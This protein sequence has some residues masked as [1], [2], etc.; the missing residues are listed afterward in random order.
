MT[1][2][3]PTL[4]A[5]QLKVAVDELKARRGAPPWNERIVANDR[6]VVTVICQPPGHLNDWHYHIVEECWHVHEGTISWT[7]EGEPEPVIVSAGEWILAPA[8][9]FHFIEVLGDRPAIRIAVSV[10]GEPH[11]HTR[12]D[13]PLIYHLTPA[14]EW[15][16]ARAAGA[17]RVSTLGTTLDEVGFIHCSRAGQVAGVANRFYREQTDLVL[18]TI[19]EQRVRPEIRYEAAP[20]SAEP[21][22]HIHGPLNLDAVVE[23]VPFER[24]PDGTFTFERTDA[25]AEV[26]PP[27]RP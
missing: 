8:N 26:T 11:R 19:D 15:R 16:S 6:F 7:V 9:R 25:E 1:A 10:A 24:G 5:G 14:A 12:A 22:P 18:L 2:A 27:A 3:S 13:R 23:V 4:R 17:Y 21:F 20:G